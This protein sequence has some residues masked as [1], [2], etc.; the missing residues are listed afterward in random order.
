[1]DKNAIE[2][3]VEEI[4]TMKEGLETEKRDFEA[5]MA[6]YNAPINTANAEKAEAWRDV[7]NAM[8]EK[9][10]ITIGQTGR[11]N[12]IPSIV[13]IAQ[14]KTPLLDKVRVFTGRDSQTNV[15]VWNPSVAEPV[16]YAEGTTSVTADTQAALGIKSLAPHAYVALLPVSDTT[17][18]MSGANLEAELPNI[19]AEAFAKAMHKGIVSG[20]G[21]G[22]A[23]EGL[24]TAKNFSSVECGASGSPKMADIVALALKLQD[25]YENGVIVMNPAIYSA[26]TAVETGDALSVYRE[27]LIRNKTVE[28]VR[29]ILTSY[30]PTATT[31]GS[32]VAVGGD[33]SQYALAIAQ[34]M[35]IEPMRKVGDLNT[36]FQCSAY[37]NGAPIL[38]ANFWALKAV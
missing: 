10:A 32:V 4:R 21:N 29:V 18:L 23:M 30:A 12:L 25:Y 7:A 26:I 28:G 19:F 13:K 6:N 17:L 35:Q 22:M 3:M 14:E 33:L 36:Y 27:E 38:P 8:K 11:V 31:A 2:T 37:F 5:R 24:F 9:R 15:P 34:E 1:M 16:T 20:D